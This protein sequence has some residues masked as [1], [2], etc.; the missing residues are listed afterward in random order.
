MLTKIKISCTIYMIS[1]LSKVDLMQNLNHDVIG[2]PLFMP[3]C[4]VNCVVGLSVENI[5]TASW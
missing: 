3:S 4:Y 1:F 5:S 2:I